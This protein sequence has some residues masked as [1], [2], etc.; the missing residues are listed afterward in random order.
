[1][2]HEVIMPALGM[3][4]DTGKLV[5][6]HKTVGEKVL[7]SEILMEVETDKS[8]MEV[9]AGADGVISELLCEEGDDV[10][11]GQVIAKI[12]DD[13]RSEES[14]NKEEFKVNN[15]EK[16]LQNLG[17]AKPTDER[18]VSDLDESQNTGAQIMTNTKQ[19]SGQKILASPKAKKFAESMTISLDILRKKGVKEPYHVTDVMEFIREDKDADQSSSFGKPSLNLRTEFGCG[20]ISAEVEE[21]TFKN[22]L[23][24][25]EFF[26]SH[27]IVFS[28]FAAGAY[29]K[30][31]TDPDEPIHVRFINNSE[32]AINLVDPDC[33][34]FRDNASKDE[35]AQ[36]APSF[37]IR[38]ISKS[39][40]NFVSSAELK[41]PEIV[42]ARKEVN[43]VGYFVFALAYSSRD[44]GSSFAIKFLDGLVKR[45]M[46]PLYHLT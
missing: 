2:L 13:L 37:I 19:F 46:M 17:S 26:E 12:T 7:R 38:D 20:L 30:A 21:T 43:G 1:M 25:L 36:G 39:A 42:I 6:W 22:M 29:R 4:Q 40:L 5:K 14:T 23:S 27:E 9:E 34:G 10:P 45:I 28:S 24:D 16:E 3:T 31:L 18:P 11:V 33:A 32:V 44:M 35:L 15:S 41:K 8:T